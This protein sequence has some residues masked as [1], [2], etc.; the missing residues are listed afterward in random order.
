MAEGNTSRARYLAI[1]FENDALRHSG[2][3]MNPMLAVPGNRN[4]NNCPP[5]PDGR[6]S[7]S[8]IC[9]RTFAHSYPIQI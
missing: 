8:R 9:I 6:G 5:L 7:D 3:V 1:F 4:R 2:S